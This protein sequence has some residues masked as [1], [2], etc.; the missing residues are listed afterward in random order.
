MSTLTPLA[1]HLVASR[2]RG[3]EITLIDI[4]E[5]DEHAREHIADAVSV[6]LSKLE[7]AGL[8]LETKGGVVFHCR[9]GART[10]QHCDRLAACV[11]GPAFV[12]EGGL[13]AWK[14]AGLA[15]VT[16]RSAPL[17]INRQVQIAAGGLALAGAVLAALVHPLFLVLPGAIGAGLLLAGLTGWCGMA[18]ALAAAPWNRRAA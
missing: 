10:T 17:E 13:E 5:P 7:A 2:L 16:D 3:G 14:R 1:P 12:L 11:D 4:R 8:S 15:V 9:T 6:P 18:H